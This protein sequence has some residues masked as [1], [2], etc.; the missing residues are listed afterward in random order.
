M[1]EC[2]RKR[3]SIKK[4]RNKVMRSHIPRWNGFGTLQRVRDRVVE[5]R[6]YGEDTEIY[7]KNG[8][9]P[10]LAIRIKI[11]NVNNG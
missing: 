3:L 11:I 10:R 4:A 6:V 9:I 7:R 2:I 5:A 1:T 8:T